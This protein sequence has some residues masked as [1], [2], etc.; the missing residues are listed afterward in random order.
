MNKIAEIN[1]TPNGDLSGQDALAWG[2]KDY[3]G[4]FLM[5]TASDADV[6]K[7]NT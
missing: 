2:G 3:K 1:E 6:S 4:G 7:K 5:S